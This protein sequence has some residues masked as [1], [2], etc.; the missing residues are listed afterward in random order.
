VPEP[1]D[2]EMR[3]DDRG[4]E[5]DRGRR[6]QRDRGRALRPDQTRTR[7]FVVLGRMRATSASPAR[8]HVARVGGVTSSQLI[9]MRAPAPAGRG[10]V[11]R[12]QERRRHHGGASTLPN[13]K[14]DHAPEKLERPVTLRNTGA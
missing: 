4:D 1:S 7:A 3:D 8:G 2:G 6:V 13:S 10:H 14:A 12:E 11:S 5:D 9:V